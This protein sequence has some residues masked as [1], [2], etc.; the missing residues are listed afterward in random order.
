M[1]PDSR[2]HLVGDAHFLPDYLATKRVGHCAMSCPQEVELSPP[3]T[4]SEELGNEFDGPIAMDRD[5]DTLDG[6]TDISARVA[7][8][9]VRS[10]SK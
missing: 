10:L 6:E 8:F 2:R 3:D 5:I 1:N 9:P 7:Q 4:D